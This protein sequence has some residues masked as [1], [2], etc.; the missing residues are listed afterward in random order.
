M[1]V[2]W[3]AVYY[4]RFFS[5]TAIAE[6]LNRDHTTVIHGRNKVIDFLSDRIKEEVTISDINK[7]KKLLQLDTANALGYNDLANENAELQ[8]KIKRL[9][10]QNTKLNHDNIC[11]RIKIQ[12][13]E[14]KINSETS[15]MIG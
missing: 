10:V 14:R 9:K 7:I 4:K 8:R 12:R 1:R 3:G 5:L 11:Q 6:V 2:Q 15:V 13:L